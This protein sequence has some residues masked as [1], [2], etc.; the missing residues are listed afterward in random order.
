MDSDS[1]E[2][3]SKPATDQSQALADATPDD[4]LK[5]LVTGYLKLAIPLRKKLD[6]LVGHGGIDWVAMWL[7]SNV[8][9]VE[10][11]EPIR[12]MAGIIKAVSVMRE[13]LLMYDFNA[14]LDDEVRRRKLDVTA[15]ELG[16][17]C[18]IGDWNELRKNNPGIDALLEY[19][20]VV[21]TKS[22]GL[23]RI[24]LEP[25]PEDLKDQEAWMKTRAP[26]LLARL[27]T[28]E[29]NQYNPR[30]QQLVEVLKR[31]G[32]LD[33]QG[34]PTSSLADYYFDDELLNGIVDEFPQHL[35]ELEDDE[36][37]DDE[38]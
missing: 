8:A 33:K 38:T 32:Y 4:L 37:E 7:L 3:P 12:D 6:E 23:P 20:E 16:F 1:I 2:P 29:N 34:N 36:E 35:D 26:Y 22:V 11:P 28:H 25:E 31:H 13:S 27:V 14:A 24:P 19:L 5:H 30:L 17:D 9:K 21:G 18:L 10:I 15:Y